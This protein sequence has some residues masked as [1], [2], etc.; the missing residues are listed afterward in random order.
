MYLNTDTKTQEKQLLKYNHK[1]KLISLKFY[2][3]QGSVDKLTDKV[4]R[5]N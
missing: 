3:Q 2:K 5:D 4:R 1:I